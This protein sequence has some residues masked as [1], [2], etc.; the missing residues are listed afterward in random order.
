MQQNKTLDNFHKRD[1]AYKNS[2]FKNDASSEK[3]NFQM[4]LIFKE[5]SWRRRFSNS[6]FYII[7]HSACDE[8]LPYLKQNPKKCLITNQEKSIKI[9]ILHFWT[10][11]AYSFQNVIINQWEELPP[12]SLKGFFWRSIVY[13][14][15][16]NCGSLTKFSLKLD[17]LFRRSNGM[18]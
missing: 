17:S 12:G 15:I 9:A 4:D 13:C 3:A 8:L 14:I 2:Y 7:Y 16:I 10:K 5:R 11:R 1:T 18:S 6:F